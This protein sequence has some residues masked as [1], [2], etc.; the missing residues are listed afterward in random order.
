MYMKETVK[1]GKC[2]K[3][4]KDLMLLFVIVIIV[5][6]WKLKSARAATI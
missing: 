4:Q 6:F 1:L 3:R 2:F 5:V